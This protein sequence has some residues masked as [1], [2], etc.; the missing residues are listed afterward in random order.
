MIRQPITF[1]WRFVE[2]EQW[3][4]SLAANRGEPV[5]GQRWQKIERWLL[6]NLARGLSLCF[7]GFITLAG[8]AFTPVE[9][10]R[11]RVGSNIYAALLR[12]GPISAIT[13][14]SRFMDRPP[15]SDGQGSGLMTSASDGTAANEVKTKLLAIEPVGDL[16]MARVWV[17]YADYDWRLPTPYL[18]T[19]FYQETDRGWLQTRPGPSFWGPRQLYETDHLRF[20]FYRRD[21]D[22]IEP[23]VAALNQIYLTLHEMVG[24]ELPTSTQKLVIAISPEQIA[25]R[26]ISRDRIDVTS[27]VMARVPESLTPTAYISQSI[28]SRLS[29]WVVNSYGREDVRPP[30]AAEWRGMMRGLRGWLRTDLLGQRWPWDAQAAA[31]FDQHYP[32]RKPINLATL[33]SWSETPWEDDQNRRLWQAGAAETLLNYVVATY[34]RDQLPVLV[35]GLRQHDNWDDLIP[36]VFDESVVEFEAG[37]NR[38]L[39]EQFGEVAPDPDKP[40]PNQ[41]D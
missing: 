13:N 40:E 33:T 32:E 30:F 14:F 7:A 23:H 9:Q 29:F 27:P 37:W 26:G 16:I 22:L 38:Y 18:E 5:N 8:T 25:G 4:E 36:A 15:G 41:Q 1:E 19:R 28:V 24:Q 10:E 12:D 35:Q 21:A 20:L 6:L 34:G 3:W 11:L 39:S 31:F 2:N 17:D